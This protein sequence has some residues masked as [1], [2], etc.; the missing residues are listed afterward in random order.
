MTARGQRRDEHPTPFTEI[1]L[2]FPVRG[3]VDP[4]LV[5]HAPRLSETQ[6]CPVWVMVMAGTPV[7]SSFT[8]VDG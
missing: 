4:G 6:I 8:V 2:A 5:E 7:S 3:D 1:D